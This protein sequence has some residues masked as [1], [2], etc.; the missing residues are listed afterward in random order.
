MMITQKSGWLKRSLSV[1]LALVMCMSMI[2]VT[3]FAEEETNE[4]PLPK[5]YF[6]ITKMDA[7][8]E[9]GVYYAKVNL[10]HATDEKYSMGNAALRGS[11]SY[12]TNN[13]GDTDYC[14]MVVVKDGKATALLEFMPMGYLSFYG[15]M[16]ELEAVDAS[17]LSRWGAVDDKYATYTPAMVLAKHLTVDGE[18]VYDSFNDPDSE[19]VF[20]GTDPDKHKRPAGFGHSEDRLV[21]IANQPYSHIFAL[22]VTP[23]FIDFNGDGSDKPTK[24]EEFTQ[25]NAAYVHVFVPVMFSISPSSGDQNARAQVDWTSL[26]KIENPEE[27]LQYRL[28]TAMQIKQ[29]DGNYTKASYD[30][31]QTAITNVQTALS[32]IWPQQQLE[33]TPGFPPQPKLNYSIP[34]TAPLLEELNAAI[35]GLERLGNKEA[36]EARI[37]EAK[38]VD[39]S[40]YTA[41]SYANFKGKLDAAIAVQQDL[42]AGEAKIAQAESDLKSVMDA[43]E[44]KPADY[45]KVDEALATVPENLSVYT[46]ETAQAVRDAVAAVVR[47]KNITEQDSVDGMAQAIRDAVSKLKKKPSGVLDKT[48]LEDGVYSVYGEMI[49]VNRQEKSMSNDAIHHTIKLTVKDGKYT[50]TM[51]FHGISYLNRF[52][53][54]AKL[55]YYED[56]YIYGTYGKIEGSCTAATVLSTQKNA[57]GSDVIDEFNRAGGS[58]QGVLYPDEL[59]FPLVSQALADSDG[60]I[61]LHVFVPVMEDISEGTGDQDVLLKLDWST[62]AKTTDDDPVFTPEKPAEQS[63]A[64]D[65]TDSTTGVKVHADKGVLPEGTKVVVTAVKNGTAYDNAEKALSEIGGKFALYD[66]KFVDADGN[67]VTPNGTF[68]VYYPIAS[69]T[70]SSKLEVY[71]INADGTRIKVNGSVEPGYYKITARTAANTAL[72]EVG[73]TMQSPQTGDNS[74]LAVWMLLML[75]SGAALIVLT[76]GRKRRSYMG[77]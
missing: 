77:E 5:G 38:E 61:P 11:D 34:E 64:V 45:S 17:A 28:Y 41:E 68:T 26:E 44:Y 7:P 19:Y 4:T 69:D 39:E 70:D 22:D 14:A 67:E 55:S 33:V 29:S 3:A 6:R 12:L 1:L 50:L 9:D 2:S 40:L 48:N 75:A 74:H 53:Y 51:Q 35:D 21:N 37:A 76:L 63:P 71:R 58:S 52:G 73:S 10:M 46:N 25:D 27:N 62:L 31:L 30:A 20:D 66:V 72:V 56:G 60:Y 36:L 54:L 8:V 49:K 18:P 47:G 42:D 13:P 23:V 15:F 57:D 43:L 65:F 24:P 59:E 32:N 16:M